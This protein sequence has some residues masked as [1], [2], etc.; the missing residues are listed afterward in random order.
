VKSQNGIESINKVNGKSNVVGDVRSE[1]MITKAS[2]CT[3]TFMTGAFGKGSAASESTG[4]N[5]CPIPR[6]QSGLEV[7]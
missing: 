7:I 2:T 1:Y 3:D 6:D 5:S 4:S